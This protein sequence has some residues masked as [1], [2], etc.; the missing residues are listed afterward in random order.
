MDQFKF[1]KIA[2]SEPETIDVSPSVKH[3]LVPK[4]KEDIKGFKWL[5]VPVDALTKVRKGETVRTEPGKAKAV[6]AKAGKAKA[7]E[8]KAAH[9]GE[10][11]ST[12]T[13]K[14]SLADLQDEYVLDEFG[15]T[16]ITSNKE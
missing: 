6:K 11:S 10:G 15:I 12:V 14:I 5:T 1:I 16:E 2:T 3:I 13:Y 7:V 8:A 9:N 4:Y